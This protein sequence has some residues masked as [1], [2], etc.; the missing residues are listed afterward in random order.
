ML[1]EGVNVEIGVGSP[2]PVDVVA[3]GTWPDVCAQLARVEQRISG[4]QIIIS[5]LASEAV[6]DCPPDLV[7]L[8]FRVAIPLNVVQLPV[9]QYT[10]NVNGF[11]TNFVWTGTVPTGSTE[12]EPV[13]YSA[14][15]AFIGADGNLWVIDSSSTTGRQVTQ[16]ATPITL[17]SVE[18][19]IMVSYSS[20]QLSSDGMHIAIQREV[21]TP[22]ETGLQYTYGLWVRDLATGEARQILEQQTVGF[23]WQPESHLLAYSLAVDPN[24]FTTRGEAPDASLAT[25][26]WSIDLD[27][28]TV[29][30][31]E[32]VTPERGYALYSPVWSPDGRFLS[33]D[34]LV[35]ME[36]RGPFAYY[37]FE[38]G[39]YVA[40]EEPLGIYAWSP[41]SSQIA[42]DNLIYTAT[43]EERI[44]VT[45]LLRDREQQVSPDLPDGY[46]YY[47]VFSPAGDQ[48]AYLAAFGGPD[49]QKA[50]LY[51]QDLAGGAPRVLGLYENVWDLNWM[52]GGQQII[53]SAGPYEARQIYLVN[54]ADGTATLLALGN[55]PAVAGR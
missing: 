38:A 44:F 18:P 3:G 47:P 28:S 33:F 43:G 41:D 21:G 25:G 26:I 2:L 50:N 10:V 15:I 53:L 40:W 48:L 51:I 4:S 42:Y 32:L 19:G 12:D 23:A 22:V 54:V 29:T 11:E 34:E 30:V 9:G 16:D 46:T 49:S 35:Y 24:Y 6:P 55:S 37:D 45:G 20:P 39:Q 36:G 1:V 14:V 52:P 7:G 17:S 27:T 8:T 5:L 31:S 13:G